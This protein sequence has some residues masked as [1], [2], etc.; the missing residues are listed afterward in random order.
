LKPDV[1]FGLRTD[2]RPQFPCKPDDRIRACQQRFAAVQDHHAPL[3]PLLPDVGGQSPGKRRTVL[4]RQDPWH[5]PPALIRMVIDVA[6]VAIEIAARGDLDKE[7]RD[8]GRHARDLQERL[9]R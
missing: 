4:G 5:R 1:E 3:Q 8:P 2:R 7:R 9:C 6:V